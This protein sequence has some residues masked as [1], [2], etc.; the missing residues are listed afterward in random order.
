MTRYFVIM[1]HVSPSDLHDKVEKRHGIIRRSVLFDP[2]PGAPNVYGVVEFEPHAKK[3][4]INY[5]RDK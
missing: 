1:A 4:A 5:V 2:H 3:T